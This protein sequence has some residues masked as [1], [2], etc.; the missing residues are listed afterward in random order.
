TMTGRVLGGDAPESEE[1]AYAEILSAG[2]HKTTFLTGI[3]RQG[4][5]HVS[6]GGIQ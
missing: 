2:V 1:L 5:F 6:E 4:H 3:E